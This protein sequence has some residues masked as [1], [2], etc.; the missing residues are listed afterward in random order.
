[1]RAHECI[2]I[3]TALLG[4][5]GILI[6][7][8]TNARSQDHHPLH[9][10]F[11]QEWKQPGSG[12]SCCNARIVIQSNSGPIELGDCEPVAAEIRNGQWYGWLRQESR[13]VEIPDSQIIRERNPE[14]GGPNG[15]LCYAHGRVVCFVPPDTGG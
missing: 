4:L 7:A 5:A 9:R 1:M 2:I 11:Y 10:E 15:H 14:Q 12:A 3:A 6:L 8:P 13:W